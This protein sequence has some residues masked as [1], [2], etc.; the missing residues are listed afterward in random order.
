[1][2]QTVSGAST[3]QFVHPRGPRNGFP[4]EETEEQIGQPSS[5]HSHSISFQV[6]EDFTRLLVYSPYQGTHS[7]L[8][9]GSVPVGHHQLVSQ[10]FPL[11]FVVMVLNN[12]RHLGLLLTTPL[13]A[14]SC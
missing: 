2:Y 4:R 14:T 6:R 1:M 9:P 3:K 10:D 13:L 12:Q 5:Q 11:D 7:F 8:L